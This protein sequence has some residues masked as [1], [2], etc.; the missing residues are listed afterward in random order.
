MKLIRT[1]ILLATIAAAG[2]V[3]CL[4]KDR[5]NI[6]PDNLTSSFLQLEFVENGNGTTINSGKQYFAGGA[7]TYS[8]SSD[9][10]TAN[11][12]VGLG[13]A[14]T[15][16]KDLTV[17]LG[18]DN[19]KLLDYFA[20]DG[21][22]YKAMPDSVYKFIN[23]ETTIKAGSRT[24]PI[25]IKF[26]PSKIDPTESYMLPL[27]ITDPAG[28]TVSSNYGVV[29]LHVI[30]NPLAGGYIWDWSRWDAPDSTSVPKS[31][32]SFTGDHTV[33]SPVNP[34]TIEVQTG[35]YTGPR[36]S[37]T[38][39]NDNGVFS[40]FKVAFVKADLDEASEASGGAVTFG[41]VTIIKA[42]PVAGVFQF[43]YTA[44]SGTNP[45]YIV[46]TYHKH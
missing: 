22:K 27:V 34:T 19:S 18:V 37:I 29:Y 17:K 46:D 44:Y 7:L 26:F 21:I 32:L 6:D 33:F 35:Y 13:G 25:Q 24:A 10:D 2:M 36:Y 42:D 11:L 30:G 38:F 5:M 15:L 43:Q 28:Q 9:V 3:S 40:D 20:V 31:G 16:N 8:S 4:K 14:T 1:K 23:T 39:K 12:S 45:R 41:P